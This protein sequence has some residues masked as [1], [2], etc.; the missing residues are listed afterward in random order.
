MKIEIGPIPKP[1]RGFRFSGVHGGLKARG[2]RDFAIV[3]ADRPSVCAAVFTQNKAAAAPVVVARRNV[4]DGRIQAVMINSGNANAGTGERGRKFTEWSCRELASRLSIDPGLILPCSTGVIGVVLER[5]PFARA[6]SLG[7]DGLSKNGFAAAARAIMTSDEFPKWSSR[8][9][10]IAGATVAV[11]AM[12]KGAGM[13]HPGMAT[14]LC[15]I[16]TDADLSRDA[17]QAILNTAVAQSFNIASV[18]GDTSTNDAVVLL[19]SAEAAGHCIETAGG[20]DYD[21][22]CTAVCAICDDLARMI[23]RDGEGATKLVDIFVEG[24]DDDARAGVVADSIVGSVLVKTAFAGADPNW[25]RLLAAAGNAGVD[26][27][28]DAFEVSFDEV[29]LVRDGMVASA[30][31]RSMARKVMRGDAFAVRISLGSGPGRAH[32][33]TSDL[34]EHY[35][36]FNSS[37]TS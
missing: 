2:R 23:V 16:V 37:Y 32:R 10:E 5:T 25:G 15:V 8:Q 14:M 3:V 1:A 30:E 12:A 9:V 34:T 33:I 20:A 24:L 18:D 26:F 35:V 11:T 31:V 4:A 28:P 27:D 6:V 13:I 29:Q 21:A 17:A 7:V 36:R 19:A 22:V